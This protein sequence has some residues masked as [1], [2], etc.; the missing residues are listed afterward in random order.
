M[1]GA[2]A[3]EGAGEEQ[4]TYISCL[5]IFE[6][7]SVRVRVKID[8]Q[9]RDHLDGGAGCLG[10][11]VRLRLQLNYSEQGEN[12]AFV[13]LGIMDGDLEVILHQRVVFVVGRCHHQFPR[14]LREHQPDPSCTTTKKM[15]RRPQGKIDFYAF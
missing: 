1:G 6:L 7:T 3:R 9:Q 12:S 8:T 2:R 5:I 4:V 13:G 10:G 14:L 15:G 11:W